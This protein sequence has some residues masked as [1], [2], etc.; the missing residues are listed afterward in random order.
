M[1]AGE[2]AAGRLLPSESGLGVEYGAS[3]VT[4]RRALEQLRN[5]G[6][7]RSRQGLG[8]YA[9]TDP[10]RPTL[11]E[12]E[13]LEQQLAM[14]GVSAARRVLSFAFADAPAPVRAALGTDRVLEVRR[15]NLADG[16]P[17][18]RV[19]VWCPEALGSGL[20]LDDV[21]ARPFHD[22]LADAGVVVAG[23]RQS[24]AAGAAEA[25]DAALLDVPEGS[26]VL[27]CE[28]VTQSAAGTNVL[29]SEHVYPGHRMSFTVD[30]APGARSKPAGLRL[31]D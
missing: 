26:P 19:T 3:R 6:L 25:A 28:R 14:A 29:F 27:V 5:E 31:V 22:L 9:A 12:L 21:E 8:W 2:F 15:I 16:A 10:V 18:A 1:L 23:A 30:L 4:V 24:I 7:L 13:T 17:F 20:S 11:D